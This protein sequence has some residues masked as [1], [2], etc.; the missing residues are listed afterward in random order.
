[1]TKMY[2]RGARAAILCY[3]LTERAS[4]DKI[5]YW[6][7][8]LQENEQVSLKSESKVILEIK[9]YKF[10]LYVKNLNFELQLG[11]NSFI[12]FFFI[13]AVFICHRFPDIEYFYLIIHM[14]V[15]YH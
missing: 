2:Y 1:M 10:L 11:L 6:V 8:E 15:G 5:R 3:D 14:H 7:G 9:K 12:I 4:F 13:F